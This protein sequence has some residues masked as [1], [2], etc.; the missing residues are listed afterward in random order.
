MSMGISRQEYG[1]GLPFPTPED[2]PDPG[3]EPGSCTLQGSPSLQADSLLSESLGKP[4]MGSLYVLEINPLSV[5]SFAMIF[6]HSAGWKND[7][8]FIL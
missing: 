2:L 3:I 5:V 8:T 6:S 4:S 7:P 1:S